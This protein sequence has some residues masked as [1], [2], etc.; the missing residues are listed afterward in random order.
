MGNIEYD[1]GPVLIGITY[2]NDDNSTLLVIPAEIAKNLRIENS[3]VSMFLLDEFGGN[4][5]LK[6]FKYHK[7]IVINSS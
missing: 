4:R 1:D 3:K 2:R 6:V 5:Y 7:E